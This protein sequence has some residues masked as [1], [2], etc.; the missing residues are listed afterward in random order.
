MRA[1]CVPGAV[2]YWAYPRP[3]SPAEGNRTSPNTSSPTDQP[4]SP[5]PRATTTPEMS[6]PGTNGSVRR[7]R[8][9]AGMLAKPIR[10]YQSGGLSPAAR[11]STSTSPG[12]GSGTGTCS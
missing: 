8:S 1:R 6:V 10:A 11:T 5:G 12:A 2:A 9:A 4:E 3:A 7:A